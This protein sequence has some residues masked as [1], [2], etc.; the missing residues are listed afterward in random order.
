MPFPSKAHWTAILAIGL[1]LIVSGCA[2]TGTPGYTSSPSATAPSNVNAMTLAQKLERDGNY[3]N[4]ANLYQQVA[5][6]DP[7]NIDA[8]LGI[9][10]SY[11]ALGSLDNAA[12]GYARAL[13]VNPNSGRALRGLGTTRM[14]KGEPQF[15]V[16]HLEKAVQIDGSDTKALNTLGV[17]KD[18]LG[19][20]SEAQAAYRRVLQVNPGNY[21]ARNNLALSLALTGNHG[22]SIKL[23]EEIASSNKSTPI[24]KQNLALVYAAA[25]RTDDAM[26][27]AHSG[28]TAGTTQQVAA[29]ESA[30]SNEDKAVLLRRAFG[31][32]FNGTQFIAPSQ[33]IAVVTGI[34]EPSPYSE[35][36]VNIQTGQQTQA[37]TIINVKT[38]VPGS[39]AATTATTASKGKVADE[40]WA[41]DWNEE[42]VDAA[43]IAALPDTP[44]PATADAGNEPLPA[45]PATAA[46]PAATSTA[47]A[48][49]AKS[50]TPET[51]PMANAGPVS[52]APQDDASVPVQVAENKDGAAGAISTPGTD[53]ADQPTTP[54]RA[55]ASLATSTGREADSMAARETPAATP[56]V[57][58]EAASAATAE[59]SVQV[60]A[61]PPAETEKPKATDTAM[62]AATDSTETKS[63]PKQLAT[64]NGTPITE[65]SVNAAKIYTVQIASFRK[66]TE[67]AASWQMLTTE[68]KDLFAALP[69]NVEKADLGK[70]KGIYYRL[71]A[72][73]F[74]D[75]KEANS[76]CNSLKKRSIECMVVE[77]KQM[78]MNNAPAAPSTTSVQ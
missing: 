7:R 47:Q 13:E 40:D 17:T 14:M 10:D 32:E 42:L 24:A 50:E 12:L 3:G 77:A 16:T 29:L 9:G 51:L 65:Q 69:H 44:A 1:P 5:A 26:M 66:E 68:Q 38:N 56:M 11:L 59:S 18:M 49:P 8:L 48:V 76:L 75:M 15:A 72:G 67:A 31:I 46:T 6:T 63:E 21:S 20:H 45:A 19:K 25:G 22:E 70:D 54:V 71:Q 78:S 37:P 43:D 34:Q 62:A 30:R 64:A 55:T 58:T 35:G 33:Q 74:V 23:L 27:T 60:A 41:D 61:L 28:A 73:S 53:S 57:K 52:D 4:A 39:T 36:L 2:Q